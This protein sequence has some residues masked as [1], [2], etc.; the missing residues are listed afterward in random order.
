MTWTPFRQETQDPGQQDGRL[1][2][3]DQGIIACKLALDVDWIGTWMRG[4]VLATAC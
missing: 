1:P 2:R 3:D 4:Q